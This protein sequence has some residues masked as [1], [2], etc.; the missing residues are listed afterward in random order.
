MSTF[1]GT[2]PFFRSELCVA[3]ETM[4]FHIAQIGFSLEQYFNPL[5]W[6]PKTILHTLEVFPDG[7]RL[8]LS[9]PRVLWNVHTVTFYRYKMYH[10]FWHGHYDIFI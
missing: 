2:S 8:V 9:D 4:Q 7:T 1:V 5:M 3:M 10:I 6:S